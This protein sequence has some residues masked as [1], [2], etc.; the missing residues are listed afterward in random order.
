[1]AEEDL[2]IGKTW[3]CYLHLLEKP[4]GKEI[5]PEWV[6]CRLQP[7]Y[8][9]QL[10]VKVGEAALLAFLHR[11]LPCKDKLAVILIDIG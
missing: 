4:N 5:S 1:M 8:K 2:K 6:L 3:L 9:C 11:L 7:L 10:G